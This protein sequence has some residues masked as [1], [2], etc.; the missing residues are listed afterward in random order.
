MKDVIPVFRKLDNGDI[1]PKGYQSVNYHMIFDVKMKDFYR[2]ARLVTGG[3]VTEAPTTI[4]Y[5][6]LVYR[7]TFMIALTLAELNGFPVKVAGIQNAYI[8]A[9]VTKNIRTF[10]GPDFGEDVGRKVI[11]VQALYV[12][13]CAGS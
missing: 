8:T 3:H 6:T 2:T 4:T 1:V 11:G 9:P 5:D 7:E 12:L 10:L 13:K